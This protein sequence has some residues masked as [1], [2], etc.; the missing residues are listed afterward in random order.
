MTCIRCGAT[1]KPTVPLPDDTRK[2]I[3]LFNV[4]CKARQWMA[5]LKSQGKH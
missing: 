5:K 1:D 2:S 3:C 4:A